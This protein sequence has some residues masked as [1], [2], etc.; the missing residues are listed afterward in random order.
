M[1]AGINQPYL[2]SLDDAAC[3]RLEHVEKVSIPASGST[4]LATV[5]LPVSYAKS[6]KKSYPLLI[7][8]DASSSIG[9]VIEMSR[10]MAETKEISECIVIGM[11]GQADDYSESSKLARLLEQ[12]IIPWC[13]SNYR[14]DDA[15]VAVFGAQEFSSVLKASLPSVAHVSG[16]R[17]EAR[18]ADDLG[19][20]TLVHGLRNLWGTNTVYGQNVVSMR[21]P[22]MPAILRV[23]APIL[24]LMSPK[25]GS[26]SDARN[27]YLVHSKA[28][29]RDFEVFVSLPNSY[30][31]GSERRYPMIYAL[32]ANIEFSTV[33]ETAASMAA[34]GLIEE[35]IVVG[36]GVPRA[37]G[38]LAF[39]FRRFE[40]FSPPADGYNYKD[41]LG[42]IF[43]SLFY[44]LG[45]DARQRLGRAPKFYEFL[46]DEL[47]PE[48]LKQFPID[49]DNMGLLGHSAGGTFVL[50][51]LCQAASP[52]KHYAGISPGLAVSGSWLLNQH[53]SAFGV[54]SNAESV[55]LSLGS[56]EKTNLFNQ[57]AG[58]DK[59]EAFAERLRHAGDLSVQSMCFDHETHSSTYPR[60]VINALLSA[61][62][63][64]QE[65]V[66]A[67]S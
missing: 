33:A 15:R 26:T 17:L 63:R 64:N 19:I 31:A 59:T 48:L 36:V 40:E 39:A 37:E 22:W 7:A 14:V 12:Q 47:L 9:S 38:A 51:A 45:E 1:T 43:R 5:A 20:T 13:K 30:V 65:S 11:H 18:Q 50:Y 62:S 58:I 66:R 3:R 29:G 28:I 49:R 55:F 24:R 56:E 6:K 21:A 67:G 2:I 52:F 25:P 57:Y 44:I 4:V 53:D 54:S 61:F 35:V 10:L 32:D 16:P 41:D 60:A 8:L 42:R 46:V 34:A 23:L 27:P